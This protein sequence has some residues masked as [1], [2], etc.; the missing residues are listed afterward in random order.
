MPEFPQAEPLGKLFKQALE[1][2]TG[3]PLLWVG[4][5]MSI[6]AGYPS[7]Q[8]LAQLLRDKSP[9]KLEDHDD[10]FEVVNEY[11]QQNGRK[12]MVVG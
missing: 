4:A 10:P 11:V 8:G 6:P 2:P 3:A 1:Q 5:G 12:S 7:L 9:N